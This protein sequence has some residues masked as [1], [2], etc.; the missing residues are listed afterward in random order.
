VHVTGAGISA[1]D[2]AQ[3]FT[4][5]ERL[6][7]SRGSIE[8]TGLG[9]AV[10]RRLTEAMNGTIGVDSRPGEGSTFWIDLPLTGSLLARSDLFPEP[11]V[12]PANALSTEHRVLYIEDNLSNLRLIEQLLARRPAIDLLTATTVSEGLQLAKHHA[13]DL[14]LL[15]L[16]LPD[17]HGYDLL[18]QLRSTKGA[19]ETPVVVI[20]PTP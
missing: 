16:N 5:F 2:I 9:L 18:Q 19:A 3:L 20:V 1:D 17:M 13:P 10:A 8:G 7:A 15:D 11:D 4:P 6:G 14:I 12:F